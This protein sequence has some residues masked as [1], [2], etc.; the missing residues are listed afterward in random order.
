VRT[1]RVIVAIENVQRALVIMGLLAILAQGTAFG[2]RSVW[3]GMSI[4][5]RVL[6]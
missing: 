5:I 1:L 4:G 2:N 3:S 6:E